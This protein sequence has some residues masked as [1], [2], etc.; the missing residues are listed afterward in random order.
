MD[1]K[2]K[3]EQIHIRITEEE[4][5]EITY[6][7]E[8]LNLSVSQ[9]VLQCVHR[10]RIVVCENFPELLVQLSRLGNNLNQI[11][12]I[13]NTNDSVTYE[14]IF[15]AKDILSKCYDEMRKLV[16]YI[17]EPEMKI[18][19]EDKISEEALEEIKNAVAIINKQVN[20]IRTFEKIESIDGEM[21][22]DSKND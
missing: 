1:K 15:Q 21:I 2:Q 22:G 7:A 5:A 3:S 16:E 19:K 18:K 6:N 20:S 9:Y 17:C 11:A 4:K 8:L 13:A 12:R 10:K 14:N